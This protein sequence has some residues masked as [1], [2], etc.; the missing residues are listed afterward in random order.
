MFEEAHFWEFASTL[1]ISTF[2]AF[3]KV[4]S[5]ST[6]DLSGLMSCSSTTLMSFFR[7]SCGTA[8][9]IAVKQY[10]CMTVRVHEQ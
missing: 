3:R 6:C 10:T 5:E 4:L 1:I 8:L 9:A 7:V 2:K